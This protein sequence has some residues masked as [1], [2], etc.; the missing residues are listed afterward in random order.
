MYYS[1]CCRWL[2]EQREWLFRTL[3]RKPLQVN[4]N[5]ASSVNSNKTCNMQTTRL[6]WEIRLTL[7]SISPAALLGGFLRFLVT[8]HFLSVSCLFSLKMFRHSWALRNW[9]SLHCRHFLNEVEGIVWGTEF[10]ER[11][12]KQSSCGIYIKRAIHPRRTAKSKVGNCSR[13]WE[14]S[15]LQLV[16]LGLFFVWML[17]SPE[18]RAFTVANSWYKLSLDFV[19]FAVTA[20][21]MQSIQIQLEVSDL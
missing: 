5:Q 21:I 17:T 13:Y 14:K 19:F 15:Q 8:A 12:Y 18:S 3:V 6:P 10:T 9:L 20:G 16:L 11:P 4:H 2:A 7:P 1:E